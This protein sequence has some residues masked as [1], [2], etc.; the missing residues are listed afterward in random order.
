LY[1][2]GQHKNAWRGH[3][4]V[5]PIGPR[6]QEIL[7]PFLKTDL[8][9]YLFSPAESMQLFRAEQRAR[10]QTRVQPSQANRN[11]PSPQQKP[12]DHYTVRSY[13][14]SIKKA[15]RKGGIP[16]WKPN[17]LRHT[18]GTELR[19]EEGIEAA[20]VYLGHRCP[21]ITEIYAEVDFG[22]AMAI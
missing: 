15:C 4:R 1:R 19:R 13:G 2:P 9:A 11:K 20:R 5:V 7:K 12:G 14:Q 16:V 10:R 8:Q 21:R 3:E 17:Q 6:G 22:K 18:R